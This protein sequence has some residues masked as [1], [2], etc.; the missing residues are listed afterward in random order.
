MLKDS[1]KHTPST[2]QWQALTPGE[3]DRQGGIWGQGKTGEISSWVTQWAWMWPWLKL[4]LTQFTHT[5]THPASCHRQRQTQEIPQPTWAVFIEQ[6]RMQFK[7]TEKAPKHLCDIGWGIQKWFAFGNN[8]TAWMYPGV[9]QLG[10]NSLTAVMFEW[11][12]PL[13]LLIYSLST[14][15]YMYCKRQLNS[16]LKAW[17]YCDKHYSW[18]NI[19]MHWGMSDCVLV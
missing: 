7:P 2:L 9:N 5:L 10:I 18:K 1:V 15:P 16:V 13:H 12:L 14:L 6:S 19:C 8:I 17:E 4:H 11:D 3:T